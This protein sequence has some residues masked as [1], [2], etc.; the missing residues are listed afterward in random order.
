M[1][2]SLAPVIIAT[3]LA[4]PA[5]AASWQDQATDVRPGA[6]IGARVKLP[7]GGPSAPK[8]RAELAFAPTQSRISSSGAIRTRIG[9]GFGFG[10]TSHSKPTLTLAGMRA[11]TALGLARTGR[12]KA[13]RKLSLGTGGWIAVGVG[14]VV[15]VG[16]IGLALWADHVNDCEERENGCN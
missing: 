6:F 5:E 8:T 15:V 10:L 13:E 14:T 11:D 2:K 9:E 7:F 3:L 1:R 4:A 12:A 16:V